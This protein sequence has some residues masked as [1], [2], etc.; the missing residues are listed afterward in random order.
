MSAPSAR[1]AVI[2]LGRTDYT[3]TWLRMRS[4]VAQREPDD[5]DEIWLTWHPPVYTLGM[6]GRLVHVRAPGKIPVLKSDRGGQV[7]YHGPGQVVCYLL[8]DLRR[9]KLGIRKLIHLLE[10]AVIDLLEA[11][12]IGGHRRAGMPGIYVAKAKIAALGLRVSRGC[13]Y[14]GLSLNVDCD[15]GPFANIDPCGYPDLTVTSLRQLGSQLSPAKVASRLAALISAAL[16]C[17]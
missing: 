6:Q 13:S 2:N 11:E 12:R 10:Q 17:G 14:H 5:N 7:T 1:P 8:L 3:E 4:F 15:L 16:T 9:R